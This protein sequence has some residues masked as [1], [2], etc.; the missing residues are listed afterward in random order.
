MR[1]LIG[2]S[3]DPRV[4]GIPGAFRME[5]DKEMRFGSKSGIKLKHYSGFMLNYGEQASG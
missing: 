3:Y 1:V 4:F 5:S 2:I